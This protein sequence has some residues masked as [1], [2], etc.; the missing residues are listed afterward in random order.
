MIF[1]QECQFLQICIFLTQTFPGIYLSH[2]PAPRGG[3][4]N[5]KVDAWRKNVKEEKGKWTEERGKRK[6]K[7]KGGRV[8]NGKKGKLGQNV[9]KRGEI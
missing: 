5:K 4:R 1:Y 9:V 7:E 3:G 2:L 8:K 6:K